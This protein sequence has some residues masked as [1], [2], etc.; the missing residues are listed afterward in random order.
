MRVPF[1]TFKGPTCKGSYVFGNA[2][3][4]CEKCIWELRMR[5]DVSHFWDRDECIKRDAA[6]RVI[7]L[8]RQSKYSI[9]DTYGKVD[10][11]VAADLI[12]KIRQEFWAGSPAAAPSE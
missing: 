6:E 11:V 4:T 8:V 5:E 10:V 2:C 3:G 7:E 9:N 12:H 1:E